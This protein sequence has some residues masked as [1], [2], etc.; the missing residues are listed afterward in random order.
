MLFV[1]CCAI[2]GC[3]AGEDAPLQLDTPIRGGYAVGST[4]MR[5]APEFEGIGD[6]AM[7]DALQ[8]RLGRPERRDFIVDMLQHPEATWITDI[9]VPDEPALYGPASGTTLPVLTYLTYPSAPQDQKN[10][11]TFPYYNGRYG[12]FEDM[13]EPGETPSFADP[14][15]RYPL[16]IIAHGAF[17]H[18]LYEVQHAHELASNGY[19]VA[20]IT[21]GDERSGDLDGD[22]RHA[23]YLRPL[24]TKGVL[25]SI[26]ES[27]MFGPHVDADNIGITGHSFGGLTALAVAGGA[28]YGNSASVVDERIRAAGISA[29]WVGGHYDGEDVLA[30][31]ADNQSLER[32]DIPVICFFGTRDEAALASV[33]LPA[34]RKLSG[35]TY[36]VELVDQP[37]IFDGPSWEDRNKWELLFLD[38]FLKADAAALEMLA[39]GSSAKG[40]NED[41][42]LFDYQRAADSPAH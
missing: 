3:S 25:D 37:H 12:E 17:S 33:I 19:V 26:L 8:G 29:P 31:G 16:V 35:P 38:A 7:Q 21:Y 14:D 30:F 42:Q 13:L 23:A 39:S 24:L 11:Y 15:A 1:C 22:N 2:S 18:G 20:V 28:V 27:E 4:N 36:V 40:G 9:A 34:M 32:V 5:L 41:R 10:P 6:D